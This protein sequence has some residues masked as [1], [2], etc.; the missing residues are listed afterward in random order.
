MIGVGVVQFSVAMAVVQWAY[1]GH[2][3]ATNYISD[4]GNTATSP[5]RGLQRLEPGPGHPRS[6][7]DPVRVERFS[8]RV[9]RVVGLGLLMI[10]SLGA[11]LVGLFPENVNPTVHGLASLTVLGPGGV[12]LL[13][14]ATGMKVGTG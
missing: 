14:L 6:R 13:F 2:S 11:I 4:L 7:R 12:A 5:E 8:A 1:P 3:D 10:V 9:N